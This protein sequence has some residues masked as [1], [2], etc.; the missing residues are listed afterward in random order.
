ME[1]PSNITITTLALSLGLALGTAGKAS[2]DLLPE[3]VELAKLVRDNPDQV[4]LKN[5][6]TGIY[7]TRW[8]VNV[9]ESVTSVILDK[10]EVCRVSYLDQGEQEDSIFGERPLEPGQSKPLTE[11]IEKIIA[12]R[13]YQLQ[14]RKRYEK[15][16]EPERLKQYELER[17]Q[18]IRRIFHGYVGLPTD[19]A[20]VERELNIVSDGKI[21]KRDTLTIDCNAPSLTLIDKGLD[22]VH[23]GQADS[24]ALNKVYRDKAKLISAK[25]RQRIIPL[26]SP[27]FPVK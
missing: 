9:R 16:H 26:Q 13:V 25:I 22:G 27:L 19:A 21:D 6:E 23:A 7:D 20:S 17:K 18:G 10:G 5:V 2:A 12:G 11:V 8:D 24:E 14:F 15:E 4:L 3:A 1:K